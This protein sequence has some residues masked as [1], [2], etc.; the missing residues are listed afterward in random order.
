MS[1]QVILQREPGF[2][3]RIHAHTV[4]RRL[5]E[6]AAQLVRRNVDAVAAAGY[7]ELRRAELSARGLRRAA[8]AKEAQTARCELEAEFRRET[9]VDLAWRMSATSRRLAREAEAR[10]RDTQ[11]HLLTWLA[12][13]RSAASLRSALV[14][15]IERR[16]RLVQMRAAVRI[17]TL[18]YR[19]YKRRRT[20]KREADALVRLAL[21][22]P[23]MLR[24]WRVRF[25]GRKASI[26]ASYL[27]E[28][29][30]FARLQLAVKQFRR[31]IVK[32]QRIAREWLS[33]KRARFEILELQFA[34][35]DAERNREHEQRRAAQI[36]RIKD[37][38]DR[39]L[40]VKGKA[41]AAARARAFALEAVGGRKAV[42]ALRSEVEAARARLCSRFLGPD[43]QQ[44]PQISPMVR[45]K[46][47][48]LYARKMRVRY[49][50]E[51]AAYRMKLAVWSE[52]QASQTEIR[53]FARH[54]ADSLGNRASAEHL[55]AQIRAVV[56]DP[57]PPRRPPRYLV[58]P[59]DL[60]AQVIQ[61][62]V[63]HSL[64]LA[65]RGATVGGP[66]GGGGVHGR[67]IL[68]ASAGADHGRAAEDVLFDP[69]DA[70]ARHTLPPGA[71]RGNLGDADAEAGHW[72]LDFP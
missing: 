70:P 71:K 14:E 32:A 27:R 57:E 39:R 3:D 2:V 25:L 9:E 35:A 19:Q 26:I 5:R 63:E 29:S 49:L 30:S 55:R 40:E 47:L 64:R 68:K 33:C 53:A 12:L 4:K 45:G 41:A 67:G 62:A 54:Y 56:P 65:E 1:L 58:L 51:Y 46:M 44:L 8:R 22:L 42:D 34:R 36:R 18:H 13:E 52:L 24:H 20:S 10:V 59:R 69:F 17:I 7:A 50:R 31:R 37:S 66:A 43:S 6:G 61:K 21:H 16:R 28:M 60:M 48:Q 11:A 15:E 23:R 38:L 72:M